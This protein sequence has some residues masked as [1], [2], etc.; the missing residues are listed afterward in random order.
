[1]IVQ[2]KRLLGGVAAAV[3]V[4]AAGGFTI[5]RYTADTPAAR[6]A[7]AAA[8]P[9]ET[10]TEA[11]PSD[12]LEMSAEMLKNT[13]VTTETVNP[14]GLAAEI[15]AQA[16]VAPSPAGEAI[17]TARAG[18]AVTRV[19]KRLGDP[20]RRG[21]PLAIVESR[22]AAQFAADRTAA[23][24]KATL[25]QRNLARERYLYDQKVSPRVD[26]ETA[27]AEAAS[28]AAE[29]R[30]ASVAA[31]AANVTNDGRS[32]VVASPI[33]GRVTTENVSLGAFVQPETEL[34]RVADPSQIQI[35]AAIGP[36]D[37][38]RLAPGDRAIIEL[39]DGS[40]TSARVR[41]VTPTLSG[42]TRSAT[43]VLDV[44]G[45]RLQPGLAVRVRLFP[46]RSGTS[47]A[48]V[49]PEEAVQSLNARDVVFVRTSKGFKA[50]P[51]TTGQRSA[52]RIEIV[53]GLS[54]GQTI[55]TKNAFLLKAELGKGA[56]EEE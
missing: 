47:T 56:G 55:A 5:A 25:A 10:D 22:E 26:L 1:M 28:A 17:V 24:A 12:T 45:G 19:Y 36:A 7:E 43:A 3:L 35:E 50:M 6:A 40:T 51:V 23:A 39:P 42:E 13:G 15:V 37:A 49:V 21:E 44:I 34:F 14:G 30:R 4:A 8:K 31:V 18:G 27:Q 16:T 41:A 53:S 32:V 46:S 48:I 52:G 11:A 9:G 20:V 33:T 2:D 54:A 38:Q 29:A